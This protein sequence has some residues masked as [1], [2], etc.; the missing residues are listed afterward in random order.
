MFQS[1][2]GITN[3]LQISER[4]ESPPLSKRNE[5]NMENEYRDIVML[6]FAGGEFKR[7][8]I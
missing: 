3:K 8:V 2:A 1:L 5:D 7:I 4:E 6:S